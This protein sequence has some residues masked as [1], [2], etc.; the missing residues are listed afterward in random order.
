MFKHLL[1]AT[2]FS[3]GSFLSAIYIFNVNN[4]NYL[5]AIYS[6]PL[7]IYFNVYGI[8]KSGSVKKW[9]KAFF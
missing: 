3:C 4:F 9:F 6:L 2:A 7:I 1:I 5:A 8:I